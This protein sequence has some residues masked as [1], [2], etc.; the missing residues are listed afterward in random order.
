MDVVLAPS[1]EAF[2]RFFASRDRALWVLTNSRSLAQADAIGCWQRTHDQIDH[3]AGRAGVAWT[4]LLRGDSTL[5]GHVFAEIDAIAPRESVTLF[6]PA[7]PEGGRTTRDGQQLVRTEGT[8]R[9]V[10]DTE[11]ARDVT[12]GYRSRRLVDWVAETGAGRPATLIPIEVIRSAGADAVRHALEGA[13]PG[14]VIIPEATVVDDLLPV[15][16]GLL[17][18]E[19]AGRQVV[20]RSAATFAAHP[21]GIAGATARIGAPPTWCATAHRLR[22]SYLRRQRPARDARLG[23]RRADHGVPRHGSE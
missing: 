14:T 18:A 3:A 23:W 15:A 10:V 21:H 17:A 9:N 20:V 8:E 2:D 5:R 6:V 7:F 19:R 11:F 13:T 1:D 12:F 16:L 4:P 22:I